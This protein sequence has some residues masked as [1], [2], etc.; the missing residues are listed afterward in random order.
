MDVA[1]GALKKLSPAFKKHIYGPFGNY[2]V[3]DVPLTRIVKPSTTLAMAN[4]FNIYA[5]H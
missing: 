1:V 4:V 3:L 2:M 5:H